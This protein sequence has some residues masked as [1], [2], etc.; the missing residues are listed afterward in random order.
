MSLPTDGFD[1][2]GLIGAAD[3]APVISVNVQSGEASQDYL[4]HVAAVTDGESLNTTA[5][6]DVLDA[7][8]TAVADVLSTAYPTRT[9]NKRIV[10]TGLKSVSV[11]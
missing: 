6:E 2:T 7:I 11:S 4:V 9:L 10:Y 8:V 1:V 3:T 5:Y